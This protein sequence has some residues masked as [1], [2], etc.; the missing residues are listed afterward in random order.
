VSETKRKPLYQPW[1]E[2]AFRADLQ[3]G[4]MSP[5]QRWI[6]RTLLQAA[7]F[8]STRPYL[9]DEDA[10]LW[11]LA[12]CESPR[13]WE[14]NKDV[15]RAMFATVEIDG[16]RLLS[17]KRLLVDWDRL[18]E[19]RQ[20]LSENGRRGRKAQ[21]E[22]SNRPAIAQQTPGNRPTNAHQMRSNCPADAG[23][24]KLKRREE[25]KSA[26]APLK[27]CWKVLGVSLPIGAP[28]FQFEWEEFYGQRLGRPV[29]E[30]MEEFI[31]HRQGRAQ[32]IPQ[33]F[34]VVK[35][36]LESQA[37]QIPVLMVEE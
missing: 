26:A 12:G 29:V 25:E 23:Q 36:A 17:Q 3:V 9:P 1:N 11:L 24:E 34:F 8:H 14:R 20:M 28:Q 10:Q 13:Q 7:F 6:Y 27:A 16:V 4:A 35:R 37:N 15:V 2:E 5:T 33:P 21:L 18:E 32:R 22:L 31:Q 19:K 30:V